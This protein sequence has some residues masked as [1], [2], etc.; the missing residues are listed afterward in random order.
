MIDVEILN[1]LLSLN[2]WLVGLIALAL[3]IAGGFLITVLFVRSF[4]QKHD[5]EQLQKREAVLLKI[6][7]KK[8]T[9]EYYNKIL[10]SNVQEPGY[11]RGLL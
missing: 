8:D 1:F 10:L 9:Q 2:Y 11:R 7:D 5:L 4:I 3:L 6:K